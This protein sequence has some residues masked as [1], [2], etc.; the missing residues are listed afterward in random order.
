MVDERG[1]VIRALSYLIDTHILLWAVTDSKKLSKDITALLS[2]AANDVCV[3]NASFF[4]MAVK[5][6]VGKLELSGASL[7][8]IQSAAE[9]TGFRLID[10]E[11]HDCSILASL[12]FNE[13]HKDPF[14]RLLVAQAISRRYVLISADR[15]LSEYKSNG[16]RLYQ[17]K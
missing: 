3:S 10:I 2:D 16:L 12:P 4:E 13:G 6:S 17:S 11:P 15:R 14:D 1:G 7:D 9:E 8:D 5:M